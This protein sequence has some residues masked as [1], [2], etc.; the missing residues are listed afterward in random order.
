MSDMLQT[1]G[2]DGVCF[3]GSP[4]TD[5]NGAEGLRLDDWLPLA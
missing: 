1:L 5:D 3:G 2:Q 4:W